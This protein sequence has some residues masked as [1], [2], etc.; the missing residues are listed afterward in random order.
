MICPPEHDV[1]VL[2]RKRFQLYPKLVWECL[3]EASAFGLSRRWR[4][5]PDLLQRNALDATLPVKVDGAI[6]CDF[7]NPSGEFRVA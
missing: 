6:L 4:D 1:P 5:L 2:L 3:I 7:K